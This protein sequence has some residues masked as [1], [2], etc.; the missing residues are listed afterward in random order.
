ML[1]S[2]MNYAFNTAWELLKAMAPHRQ[3]VL[4]A[5]ADKHL[6]L[7]SWANKQ[8][9]AEGLS[10]EEATARRDALMREGVTNPEKHGLMF[11]DGP[12]IPFDDVASTENIVGQSTLDDF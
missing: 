6:K 3:K 11:V 2:N 10:G 12:P 8:A 5:G 9:F 4:P 7:Q 1:T